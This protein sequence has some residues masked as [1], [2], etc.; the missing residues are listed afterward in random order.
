MKVETISASPY[1]VGMIPPF[2]CDVPSH[3]HSK[4]MS[5]PNPSSALPESVVQKQTAY[6]QSLPALNPK[7]PPDVRAVYATIRDRLFDVGLQAQTVVDA[8]GIRTNDIY[9]RFHVFVGSPIKAFIIHHRMEFAKHLLRH[10]S[11]PV[12]LVAHAVGYASSS[13]FSTSFK[14][15]VDCSPTAYRKQKEEREEE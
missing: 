3:D 11:I 15:H 6:L 2:K 10:E 7:W 14:R 4:T 9:T 12:Y 8:C 1:H 13:G 5:T